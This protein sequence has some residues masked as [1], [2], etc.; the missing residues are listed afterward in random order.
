MTRP[1][2][3]GGE[4][5]GIVLGKIALRTGRSYT[6]LLHKIRPKSCSV[7]LWAHAARLFWRVAGGH[8]L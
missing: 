3:E 6:S 1:G 2:N 5:L 4:S 7:G 8:I